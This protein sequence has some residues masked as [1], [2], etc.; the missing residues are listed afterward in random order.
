[1]ESQI[2][3]VIVKNGLKVGDTMLNIHGDE[4]PNSVVLGSYNVLYRN[5]NGGYT[6]LNEAPLRGEETSIHLTDEA[7]A[8]FRN[9]TF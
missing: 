9:S 3:A 8:A 7:V 4:I 5:D 1:M 6:L 2:N